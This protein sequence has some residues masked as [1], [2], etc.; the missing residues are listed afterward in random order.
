MHF[1]RNGSR[2]LFS[3]SRS[4]KMLEAICTDWNSIP[5]FLS[6]GYMGS[7][8]VFQKQNILLRFGQQYS[9]SSISATEMCW[10]GRKD[11]QFPPLFMLPAFVLVEREAW[12]AL[13]ALTVGGDHHSPTPGHFHSVYF[14]LLRMQHDFSE[15]TW[16]KMHMNYNNARWV[17]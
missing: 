11:T 17:C 4:L 15:V 7:R 8:E 13:R 3:F 2:W 12:A 6:L 5:L 16:N 14:L 9:C 10:Y 1:N